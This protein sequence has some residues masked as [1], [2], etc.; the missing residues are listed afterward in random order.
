MSSVQGQ[1]MNVATQRASERQFALPLPFCSVQALNGL[2]DALPHWGGPFA[3][4]LSQIHMV[5]FSRNILTDTPRFHVLPALWASFQAVKLTH[6]INPHSWAQT[7]SMHFRMFVKSL[8]E[9]W[10]NL[11]LNQAPAVSVA[12]SIFPRRDALGS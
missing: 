8:A 11:M 3:L 9:L 5:I 7:S 10:V 4:F 6:N 2:S 1:E 12:P